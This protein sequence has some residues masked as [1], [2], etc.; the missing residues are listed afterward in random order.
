MSK[1]PAQT[2]QSKRRTSAKAQLPPLTDPHL[3]ALLSFIDGS[4]ARDTDA[5]YSRVNQ[6]ALA[7]L[8][9]LPLTDAFD[10][11]LNRPT[12]YGLICQCLLE[13]A[14]EW[15]DS[16]ADRRVILAASYTDDIDTSDIDDQD[17]IE[18]P[19][20]ATLQFVSNMMAGKG[21]RQ[22]NHP[23]PR[24]YRNGRQRRAVLGATPPRSGGAGTRDSGGTVRRAADSPAG[25]G[26]RGKP[27]GGMAA[28]TAVQHDTRPGRTAAGTAWAHR[29]HTLWR[30]LHFRSAH[31]VRQVVQRDR[32]AASG[33][34]PSR[35]SRRGTHWPRGHLRWRLWPSAGAGFR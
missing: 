1:K 7:M 32:R 24:R 14:K 21:C 12:L 34:Y 26:R 35:E 29:V 19:R 9:S 3:V 6:A 4:D 30:R 25:P 16:E 31:T 2:A 8:T 33:V 20:R 10:H 27:P 5:Q 17:P 15:T 18:I 11:K 22:A 23:S 13:E 28:V